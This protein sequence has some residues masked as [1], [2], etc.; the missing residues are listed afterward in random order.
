MEGDTDGLEEMVEIRRQ[1]WLFGGDADGM[2]GNS[3]NMVLVWR[4]ML[5]VLKRD[6]RSMKIK[7]IA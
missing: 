7:L 5:K 4:E 1:N 3:G 2:K 6:G